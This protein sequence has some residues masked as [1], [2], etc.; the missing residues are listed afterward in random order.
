MRCRGIAEET[1]AGS[2]RADAL[3]AALAAEDT[4][5]NAA[6][7]LLL[8]AADRFHATYQRYPG[9]YDR[10]GPVLL[11]SW[12]SECG[13]GVGADGR[14]AGLGRRR[15][16][17]RAGTACCVRVRPAAPGCPERTACHLPPFLSFYFPSPRSEVAEDAALLKSQANALL[18]ECGLGGGGTSGAAGARAAGGP[19]GRLSRLACWAG[20]SR[21]PLLD[22]PRRNHRAACSPLPAASRSTHPPPPSSPTACCPA[23]AGIRDDLGPTE[24]STPLPAR[25]PTHSSEPMP[26]RPPAGA[27][28]SDD[29]AGEVVRCAAGELHVVASVVGAIG[30]QEAIKLLT[31]QYV[32]VGGTL[33]YNAMACTT[34][35]FAF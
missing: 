34:S 28:I 33:V 8:R 16:D 13:G 19:A 27:G 7:Y 5:D 14:Q 29:L 20:A 22:P 18:G 12:P 25:I 17:A 9:A 11:L 30:A 4:A 21:L 1:G 32:P 15:A 3:R 35:V 24:Q 26:P 6:L 10:W 23:G 2:V 31:A